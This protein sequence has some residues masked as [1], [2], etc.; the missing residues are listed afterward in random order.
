[1]KT[2]SWTRDHRI[3]YIALFALL[4]IAGSALSAGQ[5]KIKFKESSWNFGKV[6]Q[7]ET[8]SHEFVF[9]NEGDATLTIKRVATSC[10]CTA[11]LVSDQQIPPGKQGKIEVKFDTRGYGGQV[12]KIIYVESN[13]SKEPSKQL[14]V[15]ADIEVP[16][17]PQIEI[18]PYNYDA[19]L[20]VEGEDLKASL[21]IFNRGELELRTEFNHR[22]AEYFVGGKPAPSPLKVA[23]GKEVTVDLKIPTQTRAGVVREYVLIK[24]NDPMRSTLSLY[25]SGYVIT[26]DQLK[27]L[28]AKYKDILR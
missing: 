17:S 21:K 23:A 7:G 22:N 3:I 1:M 26:K 13:D 24:S 9:A 16:P 28:F 4:I 27:E 2:R 20:V 14:E 10:G 6:K 19:G 8:V 18:D 11:A 12:A 25:L 5:P 15:R